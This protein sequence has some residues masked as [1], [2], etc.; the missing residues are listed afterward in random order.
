MFVLTDFNET[1]CKEWFFVLF[2]QGNVQTNE[3]AILN[4][5]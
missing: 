2:F 4:E 3:Q 5:Y 1:P